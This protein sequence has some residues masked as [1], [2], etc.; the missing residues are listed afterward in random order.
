MLL[1]ACDA[2]PHVRRGTTRVSVCAQNKIYHFV[3]VVR[4]FSGAES[5][6]F[7]LKFGNIHS[8]DGLFFFLHAQQP[9]RDARSHRLKGMLNQVKWGTTWTIFERGKSQS[10]QP[11]SHS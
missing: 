8:D 2:P 6:W 10:I 11:I 3:R 9:W 5:C 1:H 4:I 7:V